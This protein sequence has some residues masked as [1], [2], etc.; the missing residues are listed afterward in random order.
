[1]ER[2][3]YHHKSRRRDQADLKQ[4]IR[5][6]AEAHVRYG[7][8]RI[9][10]LLL[11]EGWRVNPKC[12]YRLYRELGLQLRNKTPKR[13]VKAKLRDDRA[14]AV[15]TN[16]VWAMDFVHDQL[17][18]K[19]RFSF[20][21]A[22]VI[23]TLERVGRAYGFSRVIRVD[24]STEFVSRDLDLW[25]YARGVTLDFLAARQADRECVY[26]VVLVCTSA[27][28]AEPKFNGD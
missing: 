10:V 22:D 27:W 26:R 13:R 5:A 15:R 28:S 1:M 17:A 24:R 7:Y 16:D 3:S 6:I 19:S 11:R 12:V 18:T 9:H 23:E 14:V 25:A 8:Q 2:S 4:Q 20:R 21:G